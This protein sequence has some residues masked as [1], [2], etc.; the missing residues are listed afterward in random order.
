[1]LNSLLMGKSTISMVI[2]NSY[3]KLPAA[4][5]ILKTSS[6]PSYPDPHGEI[7]APGHWTPWRRTS[8]F[9]TAWGRAGPLGQGSPLICPTGEGYENP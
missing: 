7:P 6:I 8:P 5:C 2:F 3:D 4:I 9:Q 1:M